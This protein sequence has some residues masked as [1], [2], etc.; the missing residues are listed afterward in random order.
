VDA[1]PEGATFGFNHADGRTW[2]HVFGPAG[3]LGPDV[4]REVLNTALASL[5]RPA[6]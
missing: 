6:Q 5:D 3:S 1:L 2:I 4:S